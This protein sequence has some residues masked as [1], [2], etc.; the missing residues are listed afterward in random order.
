M[1][2]EYIILVL[3]S[4]REEA[5]GKPMCRKDYN[6]KMGLKEIVRED[7]DRLHL[8]QDSIECLTVGILS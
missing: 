6:I 1:R 3:K 4:E 5:L 8:S 2:E 7:M